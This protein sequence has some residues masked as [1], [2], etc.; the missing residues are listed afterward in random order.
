M[1]TFSTQS[2]I[3]AIL[4]VKDCIGFRTQTFISAQSYLAI[5]YSI[6]TVMKYTHVDKSSWRIIWQSL[7]TPK[8]YAI[9]SRK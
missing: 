5:T 3:P 7:F 9:G 6:M 8:R 2:S 1:E 4:R